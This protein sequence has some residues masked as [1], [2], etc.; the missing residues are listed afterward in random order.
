MQVVP[1]LA[2]LHFAGKLPRHTR[3]FG[4]ARSE[5]T[6]EGWRESLRATLPKADDPSK[7][8]AFLDCC[9]YV[10]LNY[11]LDDPGVSVLSRRMDMEEEREADATTCGRLFYLAVPVLA[12][13]HLAPTSLPP[14]SVVCSAK[15]LC[16][17][18]RD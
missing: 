2:A 10:K 14:C 3:F 11:D 7:V 13:V 12:P 18:L 1:A 8:A 5:Q 15:A 9:H 16:G 17:R 4:A 6:D